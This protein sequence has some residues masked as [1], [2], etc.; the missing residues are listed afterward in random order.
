MGK[1]SLRKRVLR[2]KPSSRINAMQK[3]LLD[4]FSL[5]LTKN[6]LTELR[7]VLVDYYNKKTTSEASKIWKERKLTNRDLKKLLKAS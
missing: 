7:D 5:D 3:H 4:M 1:T 6:E 2:R